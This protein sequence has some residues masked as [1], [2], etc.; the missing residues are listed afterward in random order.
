[1]GKEELDFGSEG[2]VLP[3]R[4]G[5]EAKNEREGREREVFLLIPLLFYFLLILSIFFFSDL[6]VI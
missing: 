2:R 6:K 1:M 4:E 3:L 5:D